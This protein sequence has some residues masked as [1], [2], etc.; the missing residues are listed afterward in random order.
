MVETALETCIMWYYRAVLLYF[1]VNSSA[2]A[3][4]PFEGQM[5]HNK[6]SASS[7][8]AVSEGA[9]W[10]VASNCGPNALYA[11]L[12]MNGAK[13]DLNELLEI[14]RPSD[15]GVSLSTLEAASKHF[16]VQSRMIQVTLHDLPRLPMPAI[17]HLSSYRNGH[18]VVLLGADVDSVLIADLVA[19]SIDRIPIAQF[20][21]DWSGYL[22]IRESA[23]RFI[24]LAWV[25]LG[26]ALMTV[27]F[28]HRVWR[29]IVQRRHHRRTL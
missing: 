10:R 25:M 14:T 20:T 21:K 16:G 4:E 22:L 11:Y 6:E 13:P 8:A 3:A 15:R 18:Y 23:S 1:I 9:S 12:K 26:I 24:R 2:L 28:S 29:P 5:P 7:I 27:A 19:C 17:A